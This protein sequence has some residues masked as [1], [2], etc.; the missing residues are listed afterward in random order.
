MT[1]P[2]ETTA[3][4][5]DLPNSSEQ[6]PP[7]SATGT[8]T[9]GGVLARIAVSTPRTRDAALLVLRLG[10]GLS[11][12]LSHGLAKLEAPSKFLEGL[13]K[14]GFPLPVFFGWSAIL[15]E[16]LGGLL[17]A[18]GLFTRPA[19]TFVVIT[20]TVAAVDIHSGDPFAKRELALAYAAVALSLLIS[21]AGRYSL[22]HRLFSGRKERIG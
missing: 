8:L 15:S 14:H 10:F 13:S 1:T 2:L 11:L 16:F 17:L 20:L 9:R 4:L 6:A 18:L 5:A 3:S 19:A 12:A 7:S 21:G 22:D